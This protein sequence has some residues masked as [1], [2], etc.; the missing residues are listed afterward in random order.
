MLSAEETALLPSDADVAFYREHGWYVSEKLLTDAEVD[1][2]TAASERYYA[3]GPDRAL[4]HHPQTL[5]YWRQAHGDVQRHN[6]YIAYESADIGRVLSKPLIGAVAA[7]LAGAAV[8]RM[9]QSTLIYKPAVADEPSNIVP[10]HFDKHYWVTCT[11]TE[12]LTAFIPFHDCHAVNGTLVAVDGSHRWQ[13]LPHD[14][15]VHRHFA[16]R[17]AAELEAL[18]ECNAQHNG[19]EVRKMVLDI[20]KGHMSFHHCM[21]YHGSGANLSE[22]PRRAISLHLQPGDNRWQ[23]SYDANGN[24]RTYNHDTLVKRAPQGAPDYADPEFCPVLWP[25]R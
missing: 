20:P 25:Q 10:W 1:L 16:D 8:I 11:S 4:P 12:M 13:E 14:D 2:L 18:L 6:D 22:T 7:R 9:F 24:L 21:L 23:A 19:C 17:D 5:A 15:S 3:S